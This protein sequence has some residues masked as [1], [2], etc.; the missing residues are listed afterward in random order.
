[1]EVTTTGGVTT[2]ARYPHMNIK[3]GDGG[4]GFYLHRNHRASVRAVTD[5]SGQLVE[6]TGY[7]AYGEKLNTGFQTQKPWIGERDDPGEA[8]LQTIQ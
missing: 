3:I 7:A 1:M 8:E 5:S 6:G 4:A 2:R